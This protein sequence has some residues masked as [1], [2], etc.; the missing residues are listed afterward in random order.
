MLGGVHS[1]PIHHKNGV[2]LLTEMDYSSDT[3]Y[4]S[5]LDHS[6]EEIFHIQRSASD[7]SRRR[8]SSK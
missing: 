5:E 3:S 2:S 1:P 7:S 8:S 4:S 6:S